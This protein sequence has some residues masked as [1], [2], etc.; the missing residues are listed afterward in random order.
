[1]HLG[2]KI[3]LI[4]VWRTSQNWS[5]IEGYCSSPRKRWIRML[6]QTEKSR[7]F[8]NCCE[9]KTGRLGHPLLW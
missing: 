3:T 9:V 6:V 4:A 2:G 8:K 5:K 1:M 7:W